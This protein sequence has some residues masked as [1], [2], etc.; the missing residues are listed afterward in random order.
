[1]GNDL[2][3]FIDTVIRRPTLVSGNSS[4]GVLAAWLAAYAKPDQVR[5]V[6][7]EDPP[8]FASEV[9]PACGHSIRQSLG[10]MFALANKWL[11]DQ[12]SIGDW[13]GMQAAGPKEVP[14]H[15]FMALVRMGIAQPP[16]PDGP[17]EA[18][19]NFREYDPEWARSF[20]TGTATASVDHQR[21]F[22]SIKVPVLVT[23]HWRA[24]DPDT[25]AL[26]APSQTNRSPGPR[27]LS[28]R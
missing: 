20:W 5:A 4:G 24:I 3:R 23:H 10:P 15:V 21:L 1:M 12:W 11:G 18:P 16:S 17:G 14:M 22:S 7:C 8:F 19:Q 27:H 13:A 26:M 28:P 2:V 9:N 25:G 6:V